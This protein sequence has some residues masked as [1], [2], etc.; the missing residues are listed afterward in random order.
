[1]SKPYPLA[2]SVLFV[3]AAVGKRTTRAGSQPDLKSFPGRN[4]MFMRMFL[5]TAQ[6]TITCDSAG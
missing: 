5:N 6:G 3:W 4:A 2:D 1:M